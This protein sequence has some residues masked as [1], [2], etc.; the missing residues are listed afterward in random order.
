MRIESQCLALGSAQRM[1]QI[2]QSLALP[3]T[4]EPNGGTRPVNRGYL[5]RLHLRSYRT[6]VIENK[7]LTTNTVNY[8]SSSPRRVHLTSRDSLAHIQCMAYVHSDLLRWVTKETDFYSCSFL[9]NASDDHAHGFQSSPLSVSCLGGALL[10]D[11]PGSNRAAC[12][13]HS[14]HRIYELERT[15]QSRGPK[16]QGQ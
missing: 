6:C 12:S 8:G 15:M 11:S 9:V 7:Y 16:C 1:H 14:G 2:L 4:V 5:K 13:A 10:R 3:Y